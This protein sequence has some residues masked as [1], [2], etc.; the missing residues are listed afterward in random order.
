M[1]RGAIGLIDLVAGSLDVITESDQFFGCPSWDADGTALVFE[2]MARSSARF[3]SGGDGP[4]AVVVA[5]PPGFDSG[6][7]FR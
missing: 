3:E 4:G 6:S 1:T 5:S 7:V 2:S